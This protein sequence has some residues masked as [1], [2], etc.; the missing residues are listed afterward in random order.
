MKETFSIQFAELKALAA[1]VV[2]TLAKTYTPNAKVLFLDGDLG[3]GKTTFTK[4]IGEA[5]GISEDSINSPT[6]ILK[7]EYPVPHVTFK[8][9]IHIDAYRFDSRKEVEALKLMHDYDDLDT[10][11]VVEWPEKLFGTL[12][13]DM[14]IAFAHVDDN[15]LAR[16]VTISYDR[17]D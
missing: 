7:K 15:E 8:K 9:L 12:S 16:T 4:Q 14:R 11:I 13:E 2:D 5:L 6:F 1:Q 3:A 10:L 17:K